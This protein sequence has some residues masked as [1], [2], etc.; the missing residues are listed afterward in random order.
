M[1]GFREKKAPG[2]RD[3][4]W[5]IAFALKLDKSETEKLFN[6]YGMTI[7]GGYH[8]GNDEKGRRIAVRRE[9][10]IRG[11]LECEIYSIRELNKFLQSKGLKALGA[12]T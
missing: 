5:A 10:I 9:L 8:N 11:F 1:R 3:I 12:D 7:Y 6:S 4:I 2:T